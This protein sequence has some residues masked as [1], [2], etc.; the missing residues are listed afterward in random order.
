MTAGP[1]GSRSIVDEQCAS[2]RLGRYDIFA[3]E[4]KAPKRY[5]ALLT[6]IPAAYFSFNESVNVFVIGFVI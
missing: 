2:R 3:A 5:I 1:S 4:L 6:H